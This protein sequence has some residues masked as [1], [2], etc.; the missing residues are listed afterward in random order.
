MT[1]VDGAQLRR[2]LSSAYAEI[3]ANTRLRLGVW[4]IAFILGWQVFGVLDDYLGKLQAEYRSEQIGYARLRAAADED[5]WQGRAEE[6]RRRRVSFEQRL[7]AADSKGF[8]Q[9][10]VQ[11][12]LG[13]ELRKAGMPEARIDARV[14]EE[15]AIKGV[16]RV[17]ANVEGEGDWARVAPLLAAVEANEHT[18]SVERFEL[19]QAGRWRF[20][21]SIAAYFQ[22]PNKAR[23]GPA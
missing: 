23:N 16:W 9:A 21:L 11:T 2:Q 19:R 14:D 18:T 1:A 3:R 4:A 13:S 20:R 10:A 7:W 8:A 12:W 6:A 17:T 15:R 5:Y 22:A